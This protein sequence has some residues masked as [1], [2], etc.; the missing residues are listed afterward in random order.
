MAVLARNLGVIHTTQT[1]TG[2]F[3]AV[4]DGLTR[5]RNWPNRLYDPT[6]KEEHIFTDSVSGDRALKN[7]DGGVETNNRPG[8]YQV[9][10]I[11]YAEDISGYS[12]EWYANLKAYLQA[13]SAQWLIPY[14]F[15]YPFVGVN[16][17]GLDGAV[18]LTNKQ[19]LEASGWV[20]HQHAPENQH[21]DPGPLDTNRLKGP[22]M[23]HVPAEIQQVLKDAGFYT[24]T[25]DELYGDA[26]KHAI[27]A[28]KNHVD[29]Q[30]QLVQSLRTRL[31]QMTLEQP[32]VPGDILKK[33]ETFDKVRAAIVEML[34]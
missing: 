11:G 2:T 27:H 32:P 24:G 18:R 12:D 15:P 6:T 10:I 1:K 7:L 30:A 28:I 16:A 29:A 17:Y 19:W 33:A 14:E 4:R 26:T 20:G 21:W 22:I 3:A 5:N 8:V 23:E 25:V 9:E 31:A 13:R 34:R